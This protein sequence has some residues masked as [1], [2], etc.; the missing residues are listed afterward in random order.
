MHVIL[1]MT[2]VRRDEMGWPSPLFMKPS[3][4]LWLWEKKVLLTPFPLAMCSRGDLFA[5]PL[6]F[7][8]FSIHA[9]LAASATLAVG[10]DAVVSREKGWQ[11]H[12]G[13]VA[14][15]ELRCFLTL[16]VGMI[17]LDC[18]ISEPCGL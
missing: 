11:P 1:S 17:P 3:G 4:E 5:T 16:R 7:L 8:S 13:R 15:W 10:P 14:T 12:S 18:F 9:C 2:W 6:H